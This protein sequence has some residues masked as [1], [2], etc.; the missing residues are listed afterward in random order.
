M[1]C[2]WLIVKFSNGETY[3]IG[4]TNITDDKKILSRPDLLIDAAI[5]KEWSQMREFAIKISSQNKFDLSVEWKQIANKSVIDC[6]D[7]IAT[8]EQPKRGRPRKVK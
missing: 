2:K 1:I 4:A 5:K 3:R 8:A 7:R 6:T